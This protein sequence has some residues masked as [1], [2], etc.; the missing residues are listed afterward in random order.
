MY[1]DQGTQLWFYRTELQKLL[2]RLNELWENARQVNKI[3]EDI[4]N[5]V[6]RS[7]RIRDYYIK[8]MGLTLISY[9]TRPYM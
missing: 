3:D 8:I 4:R 1:F 9:C 5:N 7:E 6:M 2:Q